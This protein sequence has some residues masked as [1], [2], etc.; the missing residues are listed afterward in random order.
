M[1]SEKAEQL[2]LVAS[3]RTRDA[4]QAV[5]EHYVV[6]LFSITITDC[7]KLSMILR[8]NGTNYVT[9]KKNVE[10]ILGCMDLD[11]ALRKEQPVSTTDDPK[12]DQIK[13]WERSNR[14]CLAIMKRTILTEIQGSIAE[15]TSAK[16]FL[17]EIEQYFSKNEKSEMSNLLSKL[18]TM[19]YK[20]KG[21][22]REYI[23]GMSNLAGKLKELKL[24]L[25]DELLVHLVLI[26]LPPQFGHFVVSYNTP[27]EKWTLNELISHC[28]QEEERV[29]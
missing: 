3:A 2:E 4:A 25:S 21:N 5:F 16:R 29:L 8:L 20:G 7:S 6:Y 28:V 13:K 15:S 11:H 23:I 10:I 12:M 26:S 18:V 24:E 27:K 19:K 1:G 17:S 9:W 14:M 22:I